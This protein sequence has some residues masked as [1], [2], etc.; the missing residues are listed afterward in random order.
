MSQE[1]RS[2]VLKEIENAFPQAVATKELLR[3]FR[4]ETKASLNR[5]LYEMLSNDDIRRVSVSP[6][7]W[8]LSKA[9]GWFLGIPLS[10][11]V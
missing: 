6:P 4:P 11:W 1:G 8:T 10:K 9:P 5:L 3:K 2:L 7:T